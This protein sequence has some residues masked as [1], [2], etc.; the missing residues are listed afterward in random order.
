M[1]WD[2]DK[3]KSIIAKID[4]MYKLETDEKVRRNLLIDRRNLEDMIRYTDSTYVAS[5]PKIESF[6]QQINDDPNKIATMERL[7]KSS[8]IK[9]LLSKVYYEKFRLPHIFN[10]SIDQKRYI[11]LVNEFFAEFDPRIL[12]LI[13]EMVKDKRILL[14]TKRYDI[15]P[16]ALGLCIPILSEKKSYISSRFNKSYQT[17]SSLPHEIGH[18]FQTKDNLEYDGVKRYTNSL[19]RE[20]YSEFIEYAFVDFLRRKGYKKLAESCIADRLGSYGCSLECDYSNLLEVK[21]SRVEDG[22]YITRAPSYV[23][24]K[25]IQYDTIQ[26]FYAPLLSMYFIDLY[27][28]DRDN[29]MEEINYFNKSI[30]DGSDN[31]LLDRYTPDKLQRGLTNIKKAI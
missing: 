31:E 27:R 9:D 17:L 3:I 4:I 2:I 21:G 1:Q 19:F 25:A 22:H 30:Y 16:S 24:E 13:E 14:C 6:A 7:A 8:E 5:T 18:A 29:A 15:S 23:H 10:Q 28:Q 20:T 11:E 26:G 12:P